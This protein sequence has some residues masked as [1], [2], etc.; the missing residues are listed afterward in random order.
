M[1]KA[2][3]A[4]ICSS[5][6]VY[7]SLAAPAAKALNAKGAKAIVLAGKPKDE[8]RYREAGVTHFVFLGVDAY[9]TLDILLSC[10]GA[11]R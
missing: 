2:K 4:I 8:N 6:D 11:V 1:S 5:D 10:A 9:E 7:E 3:V